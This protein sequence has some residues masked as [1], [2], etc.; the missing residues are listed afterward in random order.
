MD[1]SGALDED[2]AIVARLLDPKTGQF[3]IAA[4]GL[5]DS[6]TEAAGEFASNSEYLEKALRNAP[7]GWQTKNLEIVLKT[8]V[9]DSIAGPP[10]VV[11]AYF[12]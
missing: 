11:A 4:A 8:T 10:R 9:T 2:F 6:G 5:E 1:K 7:S 12:W 3:T